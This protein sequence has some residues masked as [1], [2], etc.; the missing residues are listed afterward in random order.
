MIPQ[1]LD[2]RTPLCHKIHVHLFRY[3]VSFLASST[4]F[5]FSE[6]I[7][8]EPFSYPDG[9][10]GGQQGG[11]GFDFDN[12]TD[13]GDD[14]GHTIS[15][16]RWLPSEGISIIDANSLTTN[17]SLILRPYNGP[18]R[19]STPTEEE[20]SEERTG[21]IFD[22]SFR[23]ES[24]VY[25]VT[26]IIPTATSESFL[27]SS[28]DFEDRTIDFGLLADSPTLAI[29]YNGVT[30]SSTFTPVPGSPVT[31]VS[32]IDFVN[33]QLSLWVNPD[34]TAPEPAPLISQVY[35]GNEFSTAV[36][37]S[38]QGPTTWDNL[39]V[40]TTWS[41]L[42]LPDDDLDGIPNW[43]EN[44]FDHDPNT[45]D[46]TR[47]DDEDG[48]DALGEYTAGSSPLLTD[49]DNDGLTDTLE[50][51]A[52][53]TAYLPDS[54]NDGLLD[55]AEVNLHTTNPLLADSDNDSFSDGNEIGLRTD[56]LDPT[57]TPSNLPSFSLPTAL[58]LTEGTNVDLITNSN[59]LDFVGI[60]LDDEADLA[61][62]LEFTIQWTSLSP[63]NGL[64]GWG[65]LQLV[66]D[67]GVFLTIGNAWGS[68]SWGYF[69]DPGGE[70]LLN[71]RFA[72]ELLTTEPENIRIL[73]SYRSQDEDLLDIFFR[74][75]R[76]RLQGNF[77]L[78]EVTAGISFGQTL[79][80][81]A[82]TARAEPPLANDDEFII[83]SGQSARFLP[84][85]NDTGSPD[86]A[87]LTLLTT[88][89]SGTVTIAPDG[90]LRYLRD[91]SSTADDVFSYQV[92]RGEQTTTAT[93]TARHT[94][95]TRFA[96]D[97]HRLPADPPA[98][99]LSLENAFEGI[100]FDSP[101]YL[102]TIEGAETNELFVTEADG[103]VF[104]I[105]DVTQPESL[106]ILDITDRVLND[107]NERALKGIAPHPE[108]ANNGYIYVTYNHCPA[109]VDCGEFLGD[110][111]TGNDNVRLS[112][113]TCQTTFPFTA[114]PDSELILIDLENE[115][116]VH[117]I[118][119]CRFAP[120]GYLYVSFGD[121]G[122]QDADFGNTQ[123]IDR[124][125]WSSIIRIDV[126]RRPGNLEPNP[127][128]AIVLDNGVARYSVPVDNP[129]VGVST[130]NGQAL[131][132]TTVRTEMYC[133]GLR[134]PWQFFPLDRNE[135]DIIDEIWIGDVGR[136]DREEINVFTPGDNGGWGW[137]EGSIPGSLTGQQINGAN[138]TDATLTPP[139][140]EYLHV[141][142]PFGGSSVTGGIFYQGEVYGALQDT[143][144]FADFVS[145]NVWSLDNANPSDI[146]VSRITGESGIV[147][148]GTNPAT[149]ELLFLNR[150]DGRILRLVLGS[151][152]DPI[153]ETL[154][155]TNFF[156]DLA[157]LT[158]N[159]GAV[160]Y[161]INLRFWSD[162]ADKTRW[163]L[164]NDP[165][166]QVAFDA[167]AA[168]TL[169]TGMVWA[170]HFDIELTRGDPTTSRR[171]ETRFIVKTD[172]HL[173]GLSY[174]WENITN[175]LP[176]RE[177]FLVPT[178][179]S[180]L[181]I[182]ILENGTALT[183]SWRFPARS[184][185][186]TCH[187]VNSRGALSFRTRQLNRIGNLAGTSGNF[188]DLLDNAGFF[189]N[190]TPG[191]H[192]RFVS[193]E[194]EQYS[195]T[196]RMRSYLAVNCAYCHFDGGSVTG[197]W[198]GR[199]SLTLDGT[200]IIN[201]FPLNTQLDAAD[202]LIAPQLPQHSIIYNRATAQ[203]GYTRMPPIATSVIDPEGSALLLDWINQEA[204]THTNYASW[205]QSFFGTLPT[206]EPTADPDGD[207]QSN[208]D[209]YLTRTDP[210]DASSRW[211]PIL[212]SQAGE[213]QLTH[214]PLPDRTITLFTSPDL[215]EWF[216]F[217]LDNLPR[218]PASPVTDTF[219]LTTREFY[220][221]E[222]EER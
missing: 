95:A 45:P 142:S 191:P 132:P 78:N 76:T 212:E 124:D 197:A 217:T 143:Y 11:Q 168:W 7:G 137:L 205:R 32:K 147:S 116:F 93:I 26:T 100:T 14:I 127:N 101:H 2:F 146:Q 98:D 196:E 81:L 133:V 88:P 158:P 68:S 36:A 165:E 151:A 80:L 140:W 23:G 77:S 67:E 6:T 181:D 75:Q 15:R 138:E 118:G 129:F 31:M 184:S 18:T 83:P 91:T 122:S 204:P 159:P 103:R 189:E 193:P 30:T 215:E 125:F 188:L 37:L 70:A 89:T 65:G 169:P 135:D 47:D 33:N 17:N 43:W 108:F 51:T 56:P 200:R 35:F 126:D 179:G 48:L 202:R 160:P 203:N 194:E 172:E 109:G 222:I 211:E 96:T 175:G 42:A 185:C 46:A 141:D 162:H 10:F 49:S 105:P 19:G 119:T 117:G 39:V 8:S 170:K 1:A 139:V 107:N 190:Y 144:I 114:D 123:R 166:D 16:S 84:L 73:I 199:H 206:G 97:F 178:E 61:L 210:L 54:D 57:N 102:A 66:N 208:F 214:Q 157:T 128:P 216:P 130:F 60:P 71:T 120:D 134:N 63:Q 85:E 106:L 82:F 115:D 9:P 55:G 52:G 20:S 21:V 218:N 25:Y 69:G 90:S 221:F 5:C 29:R 180:N 121:E 34:L 155:E 110:R 177:A 40:A 12:T 152:P 220:R 22:E 112:R 87:R 86:R 201:G 94:T 111:G 28:F 59:L 145:G 176:Q 53:T 79:D 64:F 171:L 173:Y 195:L 150:S 187:N 149:D 164:I 24:V 104:L 219:P 13:D 186:I 154:S 62:S 44:A 38:S 136:F 131:D 41:E 27:V 50:V 167:D 74:G 163:F 192:P 161:D 58:N 72:P 113:F 182:P 156:A 209:E 213:I 148:I 92:Q 198:D 4:L 153:P 99:L 183:Q 3:I 174:R 207:G